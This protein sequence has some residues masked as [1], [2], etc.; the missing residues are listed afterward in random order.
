MLPRIQFYAVVVIPGAVLMALEIVSS[1]VLAPQFGNSVYVW[2][3][4]IGVFLAAMSIGYVW[5]GRL[6]DARP[7]LA[8]LGLLLI[9]AAGAQALVLLAARPVVDVLGEWTA[10]APWGTLV[11]TSVLFG[12]PTLLLATV[13]PYVVRL[14]ARDLKLLG[15]TAGHLYA[16]STGGSLLG[17]LGATFALIPYLALDAILRLL[18]LLTLAAG[19]SAVGTAWREHRLA[20]ALA[21]SLAVLALTGP[22]L[23]GGPRDVL[24]E[25]LTPY[26][27]LLITQRD[28]VRWMTSDG[29]LH[30]AVDV[31]TGE[32]WLL[33]PRAAAGVVLFVPEIEDVLVLGMGGGSFGSYMRSRLPELRVDYVDID[34]A[35]P[36]L[37]RRLMYFRDD[38]FSTVRVDD[39][40]RFLRRSS[41]RWDVIYTDT[42]IGHSIPFH[43]STVE[44]FREVE[45]HLRPDGAFGVNLV[46]APETPFGGAF[47]RSVR[48]VF[49]HTYL[50]NVPGG[51]YFLV[52][53]N[54]AERWTDDQLGDRARQL[55]ER[56]TFDPSLVEIAGFL[57]EGAVDLSE[58]ML[59]RDAF[60]P[61]NHLIHRDAERSAPAVEPPEPPRPPAVRSAPG[62][63]I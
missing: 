62:G 37:A 48:A 58:A 59:L 63:Q 1:R 28:G 19:A 24:A 39:A 60:A 5:G 38:P 22:L 15:G 49:P 20:A 26:Q 4:I 61:V 8:D 12:P 52:A 47:L 6:A 32:P 45:A 13:A 51:N 53:T 29:T 10:G 27:T 18:L 31:A 50:F 17:T 56:W 42:Y 41:R 33:Y 7:R 36:E 44:F 43:L 3:S 23:P 55:A 40:R 34:P 11:A 46:A 54:G 2:G 57:S 14:A 9:A 16:I 35:V 30:A 21:A 25:R